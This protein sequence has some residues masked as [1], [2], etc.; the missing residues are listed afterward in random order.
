MDPI[1]QDQLLYEG[2]Q[3]RRLSKTALRMLKRA[4]AED[5]AAVFPSDTDPACHWVQNT[6]VQNT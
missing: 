2:E 6:D 3:E 1:S 4:A 5:K